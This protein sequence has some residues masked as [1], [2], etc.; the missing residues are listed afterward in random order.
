MAE[1]LIELLEAD[2]ILCGNQG[3][4]ADSFVPEVVYFDLRDFF[5]NKTI[6][7]LRGLK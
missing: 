4:T 1:G 2:R 3:G 6:F 7:V 5:R